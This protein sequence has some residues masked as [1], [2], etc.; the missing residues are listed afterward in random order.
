MT[1]V[2]FAFGAQD[3]LRMAC[4]VIL[5]HYAAGRRLIVYACD[6]QLL[7]RFDGLLWGFDPA[8]FVPHVYASDA[9]AGQT[10]VVLTPSLPV[11]ALPNEPA[12]VAAMAD[13]V[14]SPP[15]LVNLDADCPPAAARFERI[16]EI[17]GNDTPEKESARERWRNYKAL[18]CQVFA[19]DVSAR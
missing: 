3:R 18:G 16:L 2:D 5:K 13:S 15:W 17:V 11:S 10:R 8:A 14:Q 6:P 1:R 12:S 9:L 7:A 19:H 4:E